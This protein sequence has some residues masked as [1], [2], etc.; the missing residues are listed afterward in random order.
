MPIPAT[1]RQPWAQD[2][3]RWFRQQMCAAVLGLIAGLMI[4]VPAVLWLSGFFNSQRSVTA[5][6]REVPAAAVARTAHEKGLDGFKPVRVPMRLSDPARP[7]QKSPEGV[8]QIVDPDQTRIEG[9][10]A[11]AVQRIESGDVGGAREML[12]DVDGGGQGRVSFALAE[13]FDPNMLAA[14]GT[15]GV[16][17]DADKARA[18][19]QKAFDLGVAQAQDRLEALRP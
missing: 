5:V 18:L 11:Q 14:W 13:T 8:P 1:W 17:A 12:A 9:V 7:A 4:V 3:D 2:D 10:L 19:Y 16:A 6:A 15:R